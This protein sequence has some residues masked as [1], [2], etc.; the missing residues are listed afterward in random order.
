MLA[1]LWFDHSKTSTSIQGQDWAIP[2]NG[3]LMCPDLGGKE[4]EPEVKGT[5]VLKSSPKTWV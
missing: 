1:D 4:E 2:S 3:C 5:K